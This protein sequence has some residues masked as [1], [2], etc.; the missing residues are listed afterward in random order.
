MAYNPAEGN[1]PYS[2]EQL[3]KEWEDWRANI[4]AGRVDHKSPAEVRELKGSF[5]KLLSEGCTVSKAL[6][7]INGDAAFFGAKTSRLGRKTVYSWRMYDDDFR[8][9]WDE[10]YAIGTDKLEQRI[11]DYAMNEDPKQINNILKYR[12]PRRYAV[13]RQEVSGPDG[14]PIRTEVTSARDILASKLSGLAATGEDAGD[15]GGPDGAAG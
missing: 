3:T 7:I 12:N 15:S 13:T 11:S 4:A 9:N 5:C 6:E 10:A 1:N 2:E 8:A 14:G